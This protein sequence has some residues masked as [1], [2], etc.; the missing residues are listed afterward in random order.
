MSSKSMKFRLTGRERWRLKKW[1]T[2]ISPLVFGSIPVTATPSDEPWKLLGRVIEVTLYDLTG[3]IAQVHVHLYLQIYKV[4]PDRLEAYTIF[5]G[6]ELARDYLRSLTRRKSSKIT[7]ILNVTTKDGYVLRPT[8]MAWTTYRCKS[9][10][11]HEIRKTLIDSISK[12]A[13]E[14]G[15]DEF[16][17]GIVFGDFVPEIFNLVKKVYPIRKI[18]FAKSKLLA[19]PTP[20]GPRKAVII[21]KPNVLE[22]GFT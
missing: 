7:A 21:P 3:D 4:D 12:I 20:E 14:K 2:V 10:Q 5:K 16:V 15:F 6:H 13:A 17:S 18:E 22:A 1:Y 11:R 19:V 8:V 9:S